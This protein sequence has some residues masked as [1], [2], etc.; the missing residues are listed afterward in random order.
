MAISNP[1]L[2]PF[3]NDIINNWPT[4]VFI[5]ILVFKYIIIFP[6]HVHSGALT[7]SLLPDI[8][9]LLAGM[10][11]IPAGLSWYHAIIAPL[12]TS[13]FSILTGLLA[14]IEIPYC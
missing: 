9:P 5:Y 8:A 4:H 1:Y 7:I 13:L 3:S 11:S 10:F 2:Q 12:P 14:F 6:N